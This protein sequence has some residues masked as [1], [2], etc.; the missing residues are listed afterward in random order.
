MSGLRNSA[1]RFDCEGKESSVE[2]DI[3][4]SVR[5]MIYLLQFDSLDGFF[6]DRIGSS[7]KV[8]STSRISDG[9]VN[10]F[11]KLPSLDEEIS[12]NEGRIIEEVNLGFPNEFSSG[13]SLLHIFEHNISNEVMSVGQESSSLRAMQVMTEFLRTDIG[14]GS[15]VRGETEKT[16]TTG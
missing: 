2:S 11:V 15:R 12:T 9:E 10:D 5:V 14:L 1:C 6:F 16:S 8:G 7:S 4:I 13:L 3:W